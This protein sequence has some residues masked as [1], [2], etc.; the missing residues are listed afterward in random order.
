V[1]RSPILPHNGC[2]SIEYQ[3]TERRIGDYNLEKG[4]IILGLEVDL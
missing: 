4:G 1:K 2:V 3:K